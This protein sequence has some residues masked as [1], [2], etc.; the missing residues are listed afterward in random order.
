MRIRED[1]YEFTPNELTITLDTDRILY[2]NPLDFLFG[3][4]IPFVPLLL[5]PSADS[6]I[7]GSPNSKAFPLDG[8]VDVAARASPSVRIDRSNSALRVF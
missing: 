4:G 6:N 8:F 7:L 2:P 1:I 5:S 3:A